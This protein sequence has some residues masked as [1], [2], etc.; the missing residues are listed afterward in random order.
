MVSVLSRMKHPG[1]R[2]RSRPQLRW[3]DRVKRDLRQAEEDDKW[4]EKDAYRRNGKG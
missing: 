3:E 4:R 2:T 1:R